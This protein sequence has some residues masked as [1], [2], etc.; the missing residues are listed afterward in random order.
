MPLSEV[1]LG[2]LP[3][4]ALAT[5]EAFSPYQVGCCIDTRGTSAA[6][7]KFLQHLKQS[8]ARN[9]TSK[10]GTG[11][12]EEIMPFCFRSSCLSMLRRITNFGNGALVTCHGSMT[13]PRHAGLLRHPL[14]LDRRLEHHAV[15]ELVDDITLDL[16]PRCLALGIRIAAALLQCRPP[17]GKL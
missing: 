4:S 5:C 7:L 17:L 12:I 1:Q 3:R 8:S 11:T 2:G 15:S 9:F 10:G 13:V 14:V 16:L 6:D